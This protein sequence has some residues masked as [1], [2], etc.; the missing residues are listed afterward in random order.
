MNA[1]EVGFTVRISGICAISWEL[2]LE[3]DAFI[4]DFSSVL[5]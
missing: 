2:F 4:S 3:A 5:D 1:R